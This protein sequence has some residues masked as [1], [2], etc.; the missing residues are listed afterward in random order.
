MLEDLFNNK[1]FVD[2]SGTTGSQMSNSFKS[3]GH[4]SS[5]QVTGAAA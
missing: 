3:G 5:T 2:E 4:G 1:F